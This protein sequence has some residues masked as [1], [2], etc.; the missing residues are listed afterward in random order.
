MVGLEIIASTVADAGAA[1]KGG[2]D[3]I[4]VCRALELDGLTPSIEEIAAMRERVDI[5]MNVMLRPHNQ[6]F[7][8]TD[9]NIEWMMDKIAAIKPLGIQ[10]FVFGAHSEGGWMNIDL[11]R[12]VANAADPVPITLHRALDYAPNPDAALRG[13]VGVVARVLTSGLAPTGWD[14]RDKIRDW[15]GEFGQHYRF[16]VGAGVRLEYAA[17]LAAYT[18]VDECHIGTAARTDGTVDVEKVRAF[19]GVLDTLEEAGS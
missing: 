1:E 19:R 3:S 14:G 13:L 6:G 17:E 5:A 8:Y 4:E 9:A 2:A 12:R 7:V 11:I 16:V 10:S 15:V 18:G